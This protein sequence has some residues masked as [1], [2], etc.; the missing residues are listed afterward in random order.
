MFWP[1]NS[2]N[3]VVYI[4]KNSLNFELNF[5]YRLYL[6]VKE[7]FIIYLKF[8]LNSK[9]FQSK[10]ITITEQEITAKEKI[11]RSYKKQTGVSGP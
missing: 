8:V 11:A 3:V 10:L 2:V 4:A 5:A 1:Y 9:I 6:W 7:K